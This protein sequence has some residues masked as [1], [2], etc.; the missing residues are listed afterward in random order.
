MVPFPLQAFPPMVMSMLV[1]ESGKCWYSR[2]LWF[3]FNDTLNTR[4]T[5]YMFFYPG[6]YLL[7]KE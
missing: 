7:E 6:H 4:K 3:D 5:G 2:D 1:L